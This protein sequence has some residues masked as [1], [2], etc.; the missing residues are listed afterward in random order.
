LIYEYNIEKVTNVKVRLNEPLFTEQFMKGYQES[1]DE[2]VDTLKQHA[3]YIA[4]M[5]ETSMDDTYVFSEAHGRIRMAWSQED[6]D[7]YEFKDFEMAVAFAKQ[8]GFEVSE[9]G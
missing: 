8:T 4:D 3:E 9:V 7:N 5:A 6:F 2:E 1:F